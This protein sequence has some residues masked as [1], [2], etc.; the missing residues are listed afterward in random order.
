MSMNHRRSGFAIGSILAVIALIALITTFL[1]ITSRGSL[2][3]DDVGRADVFA[4]RQSALKISAALSRIAS[5]C[6]YPQAA[7][8][9]P[10]NNAWTQRCNAI[11][12]TNALPP[13]GLD[14]C[15]AQIAA[16][17]GENARCEQSANPCTR[18]VCPYDALYGGAAREALTPKIFVNPNNARWR[19]AA[20]VSAGG[21]KKYGLVLYI[22]GIKREACNAIE[23]Q[24]L[25][26]NATATTSMTP[27]WPNGNS[28][29]LPFTRK[30]GCFMLDFGAMNRYDDRIIRDPRGGQFDIANMPFHNDGDASNLLTFAQMSSLPSPTPEIPADAGQ[31]FLIV[32]F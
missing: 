20:N 1:S 18:M 3:M 29:A 7:L 31:Y 13:T 6:P 8:P 32:T 9:S 19:V 2:Y 15:L 21:G 10:M 17:T 23:K 14:Q 11:S 12:S 4:F 27:I 30:E 22:S 25:E 26:R 24:V 28:N 5:S 16:A